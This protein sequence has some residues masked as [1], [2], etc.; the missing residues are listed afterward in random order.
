MLAEAHKSFEKG[1]NAQAFF[2]VNNHALG[3][4]LVQ[5]TFVK[6]WS[7]LVKGGKIDTMKAFL[8]HILN[9]LV[10]DNYR[11][12]KSISLDTL[13]EGGFKVT[14]GDHAERSSDIL[15]G[16]AG[17]L[18]IQRLPPMYQ[19]I[20][21]MRYVQGLSLEEISLITGKTKNSIA[22]QAHRG[23]EKLKLLYGHA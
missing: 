11:K 13:V 21:K 5:E 9:D 19:K 2:K 18:L 15:D 14:N 22:V 1:L 4:D 20:M 10:V 3:E 23:L 8:Y 7:Y 16:K 17:F 12:H 6:T